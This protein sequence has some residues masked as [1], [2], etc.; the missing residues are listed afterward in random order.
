[1]KADRI[2]N[3]KKIENLRNSKLLVYI[4]GDRP[5]MET[6]IHPEIL[7]YFVDHLDPLGKVDKISLLLYTRGGSTLAA[8]SLVNLIR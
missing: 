2:E 7:D 8:W 5:G 3:Y 4:T 1:M 6:Q